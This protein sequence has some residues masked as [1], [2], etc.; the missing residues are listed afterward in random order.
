[1]AVVYRAKD[2]S[3]EREVALKFMA[4][5]M[6]EKPEMADLFQ[7]EAKAAAQ[8]NH[9]NIVTI[10][11]YGTLETQTFICM[12]LVDGETV[13]EIV[14]RNGRMPILDAL[15]IAEDILIA[16][17][18]AHGREIIHWDIKPS[19]I[20]RNDRGWCKLM[21]FGLPTSVSDGGKTTM[22]T[23]TPIYMAPEQFTG[24]N[25][26]GRS[27][28]F[29]LGATL[30]EMITGEAP[31]SSMARDD[32]PPSMMIRCP[33]VPAMLDRLVLRSMAFDSAD[34]VQSAA[35]MLEPIQYILNTVRS[36]LHKTGHTP[37]R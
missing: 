28:I 37:V 21:D 2:L 9:P 36:Y 31:F 12:E 22:V 15:A 24:R 4:E 30:Y 33:K 7:R 16:L 29:A 18:Y 3:L 23:G 20:M 8:L 11:D 14:I 17:E 34:R 5:A 32:A 35:E 1:M 6:T 13:E 25:V 10:F 26:D 19:N 27:D